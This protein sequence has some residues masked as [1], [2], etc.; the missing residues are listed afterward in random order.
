MSRERVRPIVRI[1]Q[2]DYA[3][4]NARRKRYLDERGEEWTIWEC[5][6]EIQKEELTGKKNNDL[7]GRIRL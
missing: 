2:S 6:Q 1:P 7:F 3:E 5:L 4:A